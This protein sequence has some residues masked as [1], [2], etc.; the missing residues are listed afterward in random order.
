M[1]A[2][3]SSTT[4]CMEHVAAVSSSPSCLDLPANLT[5]L[6]LAARSVRASVALVTSQRQQTPHYSEKHLLGS[7]PSFRKS[8]VAFQQQVMR[9][10]PDVATVRLGPFELLSIGKPDVVNEVLVAQQDAFVKSYGLSLF[11]Q[12]LLGNGLLTSEGSEHRRHRRLIAPA[13]GQGQMRDYA[14]VMSRRGEVL[15]EGMLNR[16]DVDITQEAMRVALEIAAEALFGADLTGQASRIGEV[17]TDAIEGLQAT[18]TVSLPLPPFVPTPTNRRLQRAVRKLDQVVYKMIGDRRRA[19]EQRNDVLSLLLSARDGDGSSMSDRQVRDEV[20]TLFLAGHETTAVSLIWTLVLLARHPDI[21]RKVEEEVDRVLG[22]RAPCFED[23]EQLSL[24]LRVLKESMRLFPPVYML[25]R[26]ATRAT[27]VGGHRVRKN[28]VML[29]NTF[30]MHHRA[31]LYPDP[32]RFNPDRFL[33]ENE[34]KR[35]RLAYLPF[36]AGPRV[37]IGQ[38]FA[39]LEG[40]MVLAS[41]LRRARF[42]L[43]E[44]HRVIEFHPLITLRPKGA[45]MMSVIPRHPSLQVPSDRHVG[46]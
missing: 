41:W 26:R 33:P 45:V 28:Q 46:P 38:Q 16:S 10:Y 15:L 19:K 39:L 2:N 23:A 43:V 13:F 42:D 4:E 21:R 34:A 5:L 44:P 8:R 17:V 18:M 3:R 37:C 9:Q 20:M 40:Q 25:G 6:S 35:P 22:G 36:G 12:P 32:E 29:I 11:A 1:T 30:G 14:A 7:L 24:T 31:D 27:S